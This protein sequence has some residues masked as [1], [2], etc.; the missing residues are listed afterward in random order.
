MIIVGWK[1]SDRVSER[2]EFVRLASVKGAN[3][4][5]LCERFEVSRKTGYKWLNRWRVEGDQGLVD[6]SRRPKS[7]PGQTSGSMEQAVVELRLKH[8]AWGGRTLR[9][10]LQTLGHS[11]VPSASSITRIL[12]RHGLICPK[13]SF[14]RQPHKPFERAL[15]NDLWQIDFKGD[16]GLTCGERCYPLTILDDHSRYSLGI[17]ACT[18]QRHLTV[19]EHFRKVFSRYGIPRAIYVD[20][21]NPWGNS[22]GPM[23]HSKLSVWLLRHDIEV[24]HGRPYHPQGR[25]KIER[26]HRTL[27]REVLQERVMASS[28]EAQ[29]AFDPWRRIY[30]HERPHQALDYEVPSRRY[31][32]S[33]RP[34]TEVME[35]FEYGDRFE[36][37]AVHQSTG[38]ISFQRKTYKLS[39]AL[40]GQRVGLAPTLTDGIWEI[41]YCRY[42]IGLLDQHRGKVTYNRR[43]IKSRSARFN[44]PAHGNNWPK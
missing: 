9:K 13:D 37:R 44:Q 27:K 15:P 20:N 24:I 22:L 40:C 39:Q 21:G 17:F 14:E 32:I 41:Y 29:A 31:R 12:H 36:T 1:E 33:D 25:G 19:K 30:N 34:F 6:Q 11:D 16:F 4:S 10:R 35:E 28:E 2:L 38:Q 5:L 23:R 18:D 43:L 26:F 3:L 8:P 42:P 7:S